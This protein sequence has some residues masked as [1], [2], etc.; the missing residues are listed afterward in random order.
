M[1]KEGPLRLDSRYSL[2]L[3]LLCVVLPAALAV[4]VVFNCAQI[5]F[6]AYRTKQTVSS[7]VQR[8]LAMVHGPST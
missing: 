8:I 6:D 5:V 2:S 7:D 3:K 1:N 4:S